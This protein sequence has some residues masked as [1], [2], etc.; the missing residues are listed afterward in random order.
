M[1]KAE[2]CKKLGNLLM[3]KEAYVPSTVSGFKKLVNRINKTI[4]NLR[5]AGALTIG[6]ALAS[7]ASDVAMTRFY[8]L[9]K[10]HKPGVPLRSIVSLRGTPNF[11]LSKWL[12][13]RLAFLTKDPEWTVKLAEEFLSHIKR[14]EVE[15]DEVMVSFV[16]I[17]LFTSI[18]PAL[19]IDT[20][21]GFHQVWNTWGSNS[22]PC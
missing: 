16:V 3:D 7:K 8:G 5:K 22:L 11:G 21:D 12:Y 1:D 9:A 14:L 15:A 6:E 4:G 2:Y 20:I 13:Q 10:V 17:S 18:P 19:A